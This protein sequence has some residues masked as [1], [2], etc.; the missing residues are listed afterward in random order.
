MSRRPLEPISANI[1]LGKE[2]APHTRAKITTLREEGISI[3]EIAE[4]TKISE[5]TVKWTLKSEPRRNAGITL[6]RIGRP[7][8]YTERDQRSI[9]RFVRN[10]PKAIYTDIRQNLHINLS[11]DTFCRI[12]NS[13][14]IKNWR[15]KGRPALEAEDAK[16]RYAW[17]LVHY[18]WTT[19]WELIIFSDECSIERGK[20]AQREWVFRLPS[21]KWS[22]EMIQPHT[23]GGDISIMVWGAIWVGGRSDLVIMSRDDESK[24]GGVYRQ[25]LSSS[26][27][28]Q[29]AQMLR[30]RPDIHTG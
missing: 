22:K 13:V 2:L 5:N 19:Q 1:S 20:G 14:G 12:L 24:G 29:D 10:N 11:H 16:V 8:S 26:S 17:A 18:R 9:I 15:A 4:R 21:Q 6:K 3:R 25:L 30:T 28:R 27:Q 7:R 23:K